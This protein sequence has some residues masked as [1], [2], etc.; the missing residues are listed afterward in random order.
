MD[1]NK[2]QQIETLSE[3][4]L[5]EVAGGEFRS[6][7]CSFLPEMPPVYKIE[8]GEVWVKCRST[9]GLGVFPVP[10]CKCRGND[11]RCI[12]R[13]H[14]MQQVGP[15]SWLPASRSGSNHSEPDKYVHDLNI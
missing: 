2:N 15:N 14:K 11:E 8:G 3:E 6:L 12:D 5:E 10:C 9:C 13:Y 7:N 1:E 4:Q